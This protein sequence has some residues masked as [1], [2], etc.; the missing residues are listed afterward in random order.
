MLVESKSFQFNPGDPTDRSM[1]PLRQLAAERVSCDFHVEVDL[2]AQPE[3]IGQPEE[4]AQVQ[5][6]VAVMARRPAK[7]SVMRWA[8]T[9]ISL[10]SRSC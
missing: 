10:A 6:R 1:V 2:P 3:T 9:P 7:I 4:L 8:G 5:V